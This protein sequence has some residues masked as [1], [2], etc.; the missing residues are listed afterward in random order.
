M[1][2]LVGNKIDLENR[3]V[4]KEEAEE[5]AKSQ[6]LQYYEVSAKQ[7]IGI[8]SLFRSIAKILPAEN[9]ARKKNVVLSKDSAKPSDASYCSC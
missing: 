9:T 8:E 3:Q 2:S 7:N 4:S 6:G 5:F 1:I